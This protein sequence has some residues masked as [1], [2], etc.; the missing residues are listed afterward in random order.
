MT[1]AVIS[2]VHGNLPALEAVLADTHGAAEGYICLGDTVNY[3][4]WNDECLELIQSLPGAVVLEGNHERLFRNG[5]GPELDNPLVEQFFRA[6]HRFFSRTDLI[7]DLVQTAPLGPYTCSHTIRDMRIFPDTEIILDRD[8]VV[9]HSHHQFI[10]RIGDQLIV[11]PGSVGQSRRPGT[12]DQA[13]YAL[14]DLA[15]DCWQLRSVRY[16]VDLFL[17]ALLTRDYPD[18]CLAYLRGKLPPG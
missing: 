17:D 14:Y 4:P 10:R 12:L 16:D 15:N 7:S 18:A 3:G 8:R 2:D 11:N 5:H 6:S 1:I 9:G 13:Q